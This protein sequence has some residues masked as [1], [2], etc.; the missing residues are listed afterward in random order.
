MVGNLMVPLIMALSESITRAISP[1]DAIWLTGMA[2]VPVL[3]LKRNDIL[4]FPSTLSGFCSIF[5][6]NLTRGMPRGMSL[7]RISSATFWAAC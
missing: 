7:W 1:P 4:S 6:S 3:A 2:G 5:T